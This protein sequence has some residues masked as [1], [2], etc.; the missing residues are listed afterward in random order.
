MSA[1]PKFDNPRMT[2]AEY[3]RFEES[4]DLRHEYIQG[5][6][7][8]MAGASRKH[9]QITMALS[10]LLYGYL[11]GKDCEVNG[12]EMLVKIEAVD[13]LTYPDFSVFCG[14]P[15]FADNSIATLLNPILIIEVLSPSTESYDRGKKFQYYRELPSLQE[16][17]LVSQES[18]RIERF[19]RK[20][21]NVWELTDASGL[22]D[23]IT[24]TTIDYK[25]SLADVYENVNFD[26]DESE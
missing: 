24:L 9:N 5:D 3:L 15:D 7:V 16:Y 13:V 8:A 4:S 18:A 20:S 6:V 25:L 26:E 17:V 19:V 14:D 23:D 21:D 22:H 2:E 12:G 1:N 11:R 10:F